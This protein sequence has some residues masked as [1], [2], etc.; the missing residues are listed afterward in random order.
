M[1]LSKNKILCK[2]LAMEFD[3]ISKRSN[4]IIKSI[5]S[6]EWF[7]LNTQNIKCNRAYQQEKDKNHMIFS[8]GA[9]KPSTKF[10]IIS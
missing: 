6:Q 2:I 8:I 10:N 9:E 4:T 3:N 7:V 5:S 1:N